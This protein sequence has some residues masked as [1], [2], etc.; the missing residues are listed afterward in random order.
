M[1]VVGSLKEK[2][3]FLALFFSLALH[4]CL[5]Y[6]LIPPPFK[7]PERLGHPIEVVW[8]TKD[9]QPSS[10]KPKIPLKQKKKNAIPSKTSSSP[11]K[12]VSVRP[13]L[14][15]LHPPL[16]SHAREEEGSQSP[17]QA[18]PSQTAKRKAHHPL[19]SYPWICRKRHQEGVVA[20]KVKIDE[21]GFVTETILHKSSGHTRL[22]EVALEAL[23]SWIFAEDSQTKTLSIAFRLRS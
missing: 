12:K 13:A 11:V 18:P 6:F 5:A 9:I 17:P 7:F 10:P 20:L 19:P 15:L 3:L 16:S 1:R 8:E 21:E 22:D 2:P 14:A 23:K 4:G